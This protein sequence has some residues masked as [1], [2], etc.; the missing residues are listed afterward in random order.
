MCMSLYFCPHT[1]IWAFRLL[2]SSRRGSHA[3]TRRTGPRGQ[4]LHT[5]VRC[6]C[7]CTS[8]SCHPHCHCATLLFMCLRSH[9]C[10][11]TIAHHRF[12]VGHNLGG[13]HS[14]HDEF[15]EFRNKGDTGGLMDYRAC[16]DK[17]PHAQWLH[18]IT[19]RSI[20]THRR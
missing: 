1:R 13:E 17:A 2:T 19:A 20:N 3:D 4:Y 7:T 15:E 8:T 9:A 10:G 12:A 11:L 5:S 16:A 18:S 6:K 14:F